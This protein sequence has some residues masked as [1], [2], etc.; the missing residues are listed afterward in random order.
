MKSTVTKACHF[1]SPKLLLK[2]ALR[3]PGAKLSCTRLWLTAYIGEAKF[4]H[5]QCTMCTSTSIQYIC[6]MLNHNSHYYV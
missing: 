3:K 6:I 1:V 5:A 2:S 4:K